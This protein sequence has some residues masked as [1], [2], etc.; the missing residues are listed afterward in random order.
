MEKKVKQS[1]LMEAHNV[2]RRQKN[3]DGRKFNTGY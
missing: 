2:C 3:A 1:F